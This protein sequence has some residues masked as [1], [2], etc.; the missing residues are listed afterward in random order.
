MPST[1]RELIS[2]AAL[3]AGAGFFAQPSAAAEPDSKPAGK[4]YRIGVISTRIRGK[5]QRLNG[6]TWHFA[7]YFH[8]E[9]NLEEIGRAHV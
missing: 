9:C 7:Q 8:P 3:A 5:P 4:T 2:S 6:H 1:R